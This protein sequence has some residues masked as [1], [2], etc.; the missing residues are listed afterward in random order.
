MPPKKG[1]GKAS[2]FYKAANLPKDVMPAS[3][4]NPPR[5]GKPLK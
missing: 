5:E 4:K 2:N 3:E 1:G